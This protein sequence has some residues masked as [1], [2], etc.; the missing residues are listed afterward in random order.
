M[1]HAGHIPHIMYN[2]RKTVL[3][4]A[5]NTC[6]FEGAIRDLH[7]I[8]ACLDTFPEKNETMS[9]TELYSVHILSAFLNLT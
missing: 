9:S 1:P 6:G 8:Q 3:A 2:K 4:M 5:N 7:Y